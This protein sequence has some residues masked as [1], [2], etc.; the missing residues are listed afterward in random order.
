MDFTGRP[1]PGM[2]YVG[3]EEVRDEEALRRWVLAAIAFA[4][5]LPPKPAK[6]RGSSR[7][8]PAAPAATCGYRA[9][10]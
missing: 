1:M 3:P 4:D 8:V 7:I 5:G 10:G 6:R 9:R 2:L